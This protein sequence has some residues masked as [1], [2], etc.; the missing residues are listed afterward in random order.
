MV[1]LSEVETGVIA[2]ACFEILFEVFCAAFWSLRG[3]WKDLE[4]KFLMQ[5]VETWIFRSWVSKRVCFKVRL[6]F[7]GSGE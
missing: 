4:K 3:A 1:L 5:L 7:T 6:F 2:V